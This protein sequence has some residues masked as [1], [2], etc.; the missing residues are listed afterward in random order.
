[1]GLVWWLPEDCFESLPS[2]DGIRYQADEIKG[3]GEPSYLRE[4]GEL[5]TDPAAW[6]RTAVGL[7]GMDGALLRLSVL[8]SHSGARIKKSACDTLNRDFESGFFDA[9]LTKGRKDSNERAELAA[10]KQFREWIDSG[11]TPDWQYLEQP[12]TGP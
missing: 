10:V 4:K 3:L 9:P 12:L 8:M 7:W 11:C 1:M 2:E 6:L 5:S